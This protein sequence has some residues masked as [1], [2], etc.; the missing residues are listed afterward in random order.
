MADKFVFSMWTYNDISEFTPDEVDVWADCGLNIP[1]GPGVS[2][3]NAAA[4]IPFLDRAQERGIKLI[5]NVYGID[6]GTLLNIGEEEYE[7][8]IR[9]VIDAIGGHPALHGLCVGDEP[10]TL[11]NMEASKKCIE[12]NKKVAPHLTPYLNYMGGTI[13]AEGEALGGRDLKGWFKYVADET[14][15]T[16]LC[17]DD[18]GPAINEQSKGSFM[19]SAYD[20]AKAASYAG[21]DAWG[22]L[23]SSA[24]H[25]YHKQRE[26]DALWQINASAALGLRG[27]LW[28]RFYDK[29]GVYTYKDSPIDEF[30][31]KTELYYGLMRSQRRFSYHFGEV[32]PKLNL[33][34]V[35]AVKSDKG[36]FP[37]FRP[38]EHDLIKDIKTN[39]E[40]IVSFFE[41]EKGDEYLCLFHTV[42]EWY[43]VVELDYDSEKCELCYVRENGKNLSPIGHEAEDE[44]QLMILPASIELLKIVRK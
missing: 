7:A 16:E 14:G 38:G 8:R 22:C 40:T 23:L 41:D 15:T 19:K 36:I 4:Y 28:F 12:I 32:F 25:V 24:H 9:K 6:Y 26:V 5:A 29:I 20:V 44:E 1:M 2:P 39:D 43:G 31:N 33:K 11:R 42:T 21:C 34:K 27:V 17:Y 30:G 3:D 18:Y 37:E 10:S 35:Y 13:C